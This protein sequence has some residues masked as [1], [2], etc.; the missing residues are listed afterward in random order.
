MK[1]ISY[2]QPLASAWERTRTILFKPFS[3]E[4]WFVIGFAAWLSSL[5]EGG[6]F[7]FNLNFSM[8]H[9]FGKASCCPQCQGIAD[10]AAGHIIL[11]L[12]ILAIVV[13]VGIGLAAI[14][15][16]LSS[17][18]KFV[19]L[20]DV[21]SNRAAIVEPWNLWSP[22]GRS[23]FIWRLVFL[24]VSVAIILGLASTGV[25]I[26]LPCFYY[27]RLL[28]FP[29]IGTISVVGVTVLAIIAISYINLFLVD[30]I[31]PIMMRKNLTAVEAWKDFLVLLRDNVV[32]MLVYGIVRML[33]YLAVVSALTLALFVTCCLCGLGVLLL[34]PYIGT[35]IILPI[36]VFFRS[37]SLDYL[38]Q[39]GEE[40]V[41]FA[42][43]NK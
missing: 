18:A 23:L 40:Y 2:M 26:S 9:R 28:I 20:D 7:S 21:A 29:L 33:V 42:W 37:F 43:G 30:F 25:L 34:V 27:Q 10:F 4:K 38:A 12:L 6:I 11:F 32:A 1:D 19:F 39:F 14:I 22:Q 16:W 35:V 8:P 24:L 41:C 15:L 3:F 5:G 17:R 36:Y 13:A 31:V